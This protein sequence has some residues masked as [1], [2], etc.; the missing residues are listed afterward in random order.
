MKS[1]NPL[2]VDSTQAVGDKF[3]TNVELYQKSLF[4][5]Q[6]LFIE[7]K[8]QGQK[9]TARF[10]LIR[11]QTKKRTFHTAEFWT[12]S[13]QKYQFRFLV[14]EANKEVE[15]TGWQSPNGQNHL[16]SDLQ[17]AFSFAPLASEKI[18]KLKQVKPLQSSLQ[19]NLLSDTAKDLF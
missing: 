11:K 9:K 13:E 14:L 6:S 18:K 12:E 4:P 19:L 3:I 2:F 7:I 10:E 5:S 1:I 16:I 8:N 17:A 15:A